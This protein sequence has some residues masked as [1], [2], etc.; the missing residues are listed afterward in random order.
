VDHVTETGDQSDAEDNR[1]GNA[2]GGDSSA[3]SAEKA[4]DREGEM[5]RS[6]EENAA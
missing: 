6:G 3:S 4:K 5:E 2:K 1:D